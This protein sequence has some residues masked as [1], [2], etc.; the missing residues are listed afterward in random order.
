MSFFNR[1]LTAAD[2]RLEAGR[3]C[4]KFSSTLA[5]IYLVY[6]V[7]AVGISLVIS[8]P[9]ANGETTTTISSGTNILSVFYT[10][11]IM[12][13][14][15]IISS[16]IHN[17][18][19]PEVNDLFKGFKNYGGVLGVYILQNIYIALW[20]LLF[21]IPGLVKTYSYAMSLYIINDNPNKGIKDCITESRKMMDGNK[22]KLFCLDFSYI[23]WYL[24]SG[25]TFGI[26]LLWVLPKHE[27]ARYLFYLK[28]SGKGRLA[29]VQAEEE[30]K[31]AEEQK[32][33]DYSVID[34]LDK[35]FD[36]ID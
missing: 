26:L 21:V 11:H 35:K 12:V 13:G 27:Y 10:G 6:F 20:S 18:V 4:S 9:T 5:V 25:F 19:K 15:I 28:V 33:E 3:K 23:G 1:N 8:L 24:L 31:A 2:Y 30:L 29:E 14:L 7:I 32:V 22:W 17:D 16:K 36:S 34:E